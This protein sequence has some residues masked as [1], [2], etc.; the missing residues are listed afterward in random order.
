MT[1]I[2]FNSPNMPTPGP[3]R[4][5]AQ[6]E[7]NQQPL[8]SQFKSYQLNQAVNYYLL[9][10]FQYSITKF[11]FALPDGQRSNGPQSGITV[12]QSE[13]KNDPGLVYK[14]VNFEKILPTFTAQK[15]SANDFRAVDYH[16]F[17]ANE[18]YFNPK[19]ALNNTDLWYYGSDNNARNSG[20]GVAGNS[21]NLQEVQHIIFPE[22]ERGGTNTQLL[23]RYSWP[24]TISKHEDGD[25]LSWEA[26]NDHSINNDKNCQ[27]F[28]WNSRYSGF[29]PPFN[30]VYSFDS[31]YTRYIGISG[32]QQGVMPY[33]QI[34]N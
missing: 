28:N 6:L 4:V 19:E 26:Q 12:D 22:P 31:D 30:S 17:E 11:D 9:D 10:P 5:S 8:G 29:S 2:L 21:V 15:K 32:P 7:Q 13:F 25:H 20:L 1:S 34:N 3:R 14:N 23:A 18:G 33:A 27:F 24:Q 16:R